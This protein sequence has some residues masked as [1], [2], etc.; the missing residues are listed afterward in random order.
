M[1][2]AKT[3]K[4]KT[5]QPGFVRIISGQWRGR[6]LPVADVAGLRPTT[7]RVKETLFNWLMH[8]VSDSTVL[9]CFSGSG[10]LA[11]EALSRYA[12]FATLV[13]KDPAQAKRLQALLSTLN[14]TQAEVI[15]SDCLRYLTQP[16]KRQ[17]QIVLVDPPFRL[18]LALPSCQL[19]ERHGW[20]SESALIYLETEKE[21]P[22]T[23]IPANWQL[24]K[25]KVAGQL[26]YR[27]W[28]RQA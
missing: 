4:S 12:K 9:D 11:F 25:E 17:Y 10:A 7:D 20:L 15:T 1:K 23:D 6:R 16:A 18:G 27:L 26:A 8:D 24:L 13:E 19:L 5:G 2:Q 14:A 22:L 28:S 3:A 21:L